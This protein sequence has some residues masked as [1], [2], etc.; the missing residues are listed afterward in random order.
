MKWSDLHRG[1]TLYGKRIS[2]ANKLG[3]L[4]GLPEKDV[5][6]KMLNLAQT[7]D[8][9]SVQSGMSFS[10]ARALVDDG[11]VSLHNAGKKKDAENKPAAICYEDR[12][13]PKDF[14]T[15]GHVLMRQSMAPCLRCRAGF[16]AWAKQRNSAIIVSA[17]EG[18]DTAPRDS[19]F[20]FAPTGATYVWS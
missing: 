13:L 15:G 17:V 20:I 11:E 2:S 18:N 9:D 5:F 4:Q 14:D 8:L 19:V 12:L 10:W 16:R 6:A 7:L 3:G 1:Q